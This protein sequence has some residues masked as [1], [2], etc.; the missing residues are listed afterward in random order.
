MSVVLTT[1]LSP[2][3]PPGSPLNSWKDI[4]RYLDRGVRTV[5]RWERELAMPVHRITKS[6]RG[7]VFAYRE[8]LDRWLEVSSANPSPLA[9]ISGQPGART[10]NPEVWNQI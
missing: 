4:A 10:S 3:L 8:E 5:Q 6:D 1:P 9:Q 2:N 7:P